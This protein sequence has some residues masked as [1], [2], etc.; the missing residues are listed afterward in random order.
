MLVH[1]ISDDA[2]EFYERSGFTASPI[3]PMIVMATLVDIK[4]ALG[5]A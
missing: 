3:D 1:A 2:R 4:K 5:K